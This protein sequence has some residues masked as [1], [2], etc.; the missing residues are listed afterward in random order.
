MDWG[1]L[2]LLGSLLAFQFPLALAFI[3]GHT[4]PAGRARWA[5][6]VLCLFGVFASTLVHSRSL[7]LITIFVVCY[8]FSGWWASW[9]SRGVQIAFFGV[10]LLGLILVGVTVQSRE[11]LR[12]AL[13]PYL[14]SGMWMTLIVLGLSI[15][16]FKQFPRAAFA[17]I[18][19]VP[20]LLAS[21]FVPIS[22][23]FFPPQS[24]TLLDRP[25]VETVLF[26][27]LALL[28]GLGLAGL[29]KTVNSK[30]V[31]VLLAVLLGGCLLFGL[32]T[33]DT[34]AP[35]ECC[36]LFGTDDAVA[37][38]WLDK[39]LPKGATILIASTEL[40]VLESSQSTEFH[41]SDGGLWIA[42]LTGRGVLM[43]PYRTDFRTVATHA[44][45]CTRHV[46]HVYVG[47]LGQHF[48]RVQ[49]NMNPGWY[50]PLLS[51]PGANVYRVI[52][53]P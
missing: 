26:Y 14:R 38:N 46:T 36:I 31:A 45:L 29:V 52:S 49:L 15:F 17:C 23:I 6:I 50:S 7:V 44:D 47:G 28:G 34:F 8:L 30:R 18:L 35:S 41:G 27:P 33:S 21:L 3:L 20:L 16:A 12:L 10:T 4:P 40:R 39:N 51:L 2:P 5:M 48:D 19:S 24:Q 22:K 53:C 13:D 37:V 9:R 43:S 32:V 1:K 11:L 25:F 42:P